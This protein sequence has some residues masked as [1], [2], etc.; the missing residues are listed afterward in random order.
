VDQGEPCKTD[1]DAATGRWWRNRSTFF[2]NK[3][4]FPNI[5]ACNAAGTGKPAASGEKLDKHHSP[6]EFPPTVGRAACS[7]VDDE[8]E[9][10]LAAPCYSLTHANLFG[11]T[12]AANGG[13]TDR[14]AAKD[15]E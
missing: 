11:V 3:S 5:R 10:G 15:N 13:N 4:L 12:K 14:R 6:N 7:D 2:R 9:V 1:V 8:D